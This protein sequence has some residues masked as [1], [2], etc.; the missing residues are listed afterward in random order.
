MLLRCTA[1]SDFTK[2]WT[3]GIWQLGKFPMRVFRWTRDF[4]VPKES[5]LAPVWFSLPSLPVHYFDKHSLYSIVSP[6]RTPLFLDA[7]TASGTWPNMAW[8]CVEVD[9]MKPLCSR[10]WVAVEGESGFWQKLVPENLPTYCSGC[11]HLG[12]MVADCKRNAKKHGVSKPNAQPWVQTQ[13]AADPSSHVHGQTSAVVAQ[14]TN[15]TSGDRRVPL[16]V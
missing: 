8:V 1:E 15:V 14:E 16:H 6:A 4:H 3:R 13:V 12:H 11:W 9:L 5:S 10:V 2:I 7:A